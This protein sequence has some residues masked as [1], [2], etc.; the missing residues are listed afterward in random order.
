MINSDY[1]QV[2][3]QNG[4]ELNEIL[5]ALL[6]QLGFDSF[7][8]EDSGI[9]GYIVKDEFDENILVDFLKQNEITQSVTFEAQ[10]Q[11]KKNWNEEWEKNFD[12]VFIDDQV[13]IKAPFHNDIPD[14]PLT[15]LIEP[16]MSFGT[17]HHETTE[18]MIRNLMSLGCKE[19]KVSDIGC[20]T[21]VLGIAA[22]KLGAEFVD[23]CDIDEWSSSNTEENKQLNKVENLKVFLGD[24]S[25]I[26]A[27]NKTY[28][29]TLANINK[30]ILLQDMNAF[31]DITKAG[32]HLILSGFYESDCGDLIDK[33]KQV[34]F[35]FIDSIS[36]NTWASMILKRK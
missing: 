3:F 16:K 24:V 36:K 30:N 23:A 31:S 1:I 13:V 22:L 28:D 6:M 34:G 2:T 14:A 29:I 32:G 7:L 12:P 11:E 35:E 9:T 18:L 4:P 10:Q 27:L 26:I 8:E 25:Q 5:P 20:G 19:L 17:G 21:G 15:I 33:A